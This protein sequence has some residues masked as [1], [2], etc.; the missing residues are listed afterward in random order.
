MAPAQP[1]PAYD[2]PLPTPE[3]ILAHRAHRPYPLPKG[4]WRLRQRWNDLLF[5]HWPISPAVLAAKLPPGLEPDLCDGSAWLGV[6]PFWMNHVKTRLAGPLALATPT[7]RSF[8]ELNLRTYV[9]SR[10]SGLAGVYFYSL[11]CSSPLAVAGA[12]TLF[13]L[14]YYPASMSRTTSA[15]G[16]VEYTSKRLL[17]RTPAGYAATYAPT[18]EATSARDAGVL[19]NGTQ[20]PAQGRFG[21]D[22]LAKFLTER[23]CLFTPSRGHMLLGH[24]HHQPWTLEPAEAEIHRNEIPRAHGF[25][26]PDTAPVLHFA[27]SLDVLLWGLERDQPR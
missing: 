13:H 3:A 23:Y 5:C 9:R 27:R 17:T 7:V 20:Y 6:I 22:P 8:P 25:T 10:A 11:D 1:T 14:P 2:A 26:L 16:Q 18:C 15:A 4:P 24:I 21:L 19:E 12:R